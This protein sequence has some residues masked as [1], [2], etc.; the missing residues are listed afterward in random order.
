MFARIMRL[1]LPVFAG[2]IATSAAPLE[3]APTLDLP[4][5]CAFGET[6]FIQQYFDHDP[7][8]EAKDYRCG[9]SRVERRPES[10]E[11]VGSSPTRNTK[12]L[13]EFV[14]G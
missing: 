8:P 10:P 14:R 11:V 4:L 3:G 12:T 5:D 2:A 1:A 7:G 6:C 13:A 9:C